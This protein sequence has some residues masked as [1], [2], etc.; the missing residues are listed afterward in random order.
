MISDIE[1]KKLTVIRKLKIDGEDQYESVAPVNQLILAEIQH[2]LIDSCP[3]VRV[4]LTSRYEENTES[5]QKIHLAGV[6]EEGI[7]KYLEEQK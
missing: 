2:C 3:N 4:I 7:E 6:T 5:I 1:R